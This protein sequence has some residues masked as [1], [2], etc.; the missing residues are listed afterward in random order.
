VAGVPTPT[1]PEIRHLSPNELSGAVASAAR[2]FHDDPLFNFFEPDLVKQSHRL[3][4]FMKATI[5]DTLPFKETYTA[6]T[7]GKAKA[8]AA[9][10]PPGSYPRSNRREGL[11]NARVLPSMLR[12]GRRMP[13][14]VRLLTTIDKAHPKIEHWY[15]SLLAV[16]PSLQGKGV[17]G[18][19]LGPV[20][21]RCDRDGLPAY[22]ETQKEANVAWY[23]R[24][25]FELVDTIRLEGVAD[26]PTMW[27]ML[28]EPR[29]S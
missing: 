20:L 10:L 1:L 26:S 2:A 24:F 23:R 22:L 18:A 25:G 11:F 14:A 19:L 28:R 7:D 13:L 8:V 3:P 27:T 4:A 15:L 12:V 9:W 6:A 29:Q 16:D 5:L 17:G 21:E